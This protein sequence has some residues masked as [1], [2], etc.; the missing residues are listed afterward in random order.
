[1]LFALNYIQVKETM[2]YW[3]VNS[4]MQTSHTLCFRPKRY[5]A[6]QLGPYYQHNAAATRV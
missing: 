2:Y 1:M 5:G 4:K 3:G 6:L